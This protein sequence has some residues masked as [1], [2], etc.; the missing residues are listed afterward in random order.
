MRNRNNQKIPLSFSE[1][2]TK[3][4]GQIFSAER[5]TAWLTSRARRAGL[6]GKATRTAFFAVFPPDIYDPVTGKFTSGIRGDLNEAGQEE[7]L[8][9]EQ[10]LEDSTFYWTS[11]FGI[12]NRIVFSDTSDQL[13]G[14][15]IF[16]NLFGWHRDDSPKY[17]KILNYTLVVPGIKFLWNGVRIIGSTA[18]NTVKLF[19]EFL[20]RVI[21]TSSFY[22]YVLLKEKSDHT[23]NNA[24]K[25]LFFTA[26]AFLVVGY[27]V[28]KVW[29]LMGRAVTSPGISMRVAWKTGK[30]LGGFAGKFVGALTAVVSSLITIAAYT[31]LFPLAIKAAVAYAPSVIASVAGKTA[32]WMESSSVLNRIGNVISKGEPIHPVICGFSAHFSIRCGS[33]CGGC[34]VCWRR[35]E[36][37]KNESEPLVA[38]TGELFRCPQT[39]VGGNSIRRGKGSH[40]GR[41]GESSRSSNWRT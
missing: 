23:N 29:R 30:E 21:E 31:V 37:C 33:A 28:S 19:T 11:F 41:I 36:S 4:A 39:S 32:A 9:A 25:A 35:C 40:Y 17:Q 24:L 8:R 10:V 22:G 12:P 15:K 2:S 7:A 5:Q 16:K 20:P 27:Y 18:W 13:N 26:M 3:Y 34:Y 6:L 14:W 1:W 38:C